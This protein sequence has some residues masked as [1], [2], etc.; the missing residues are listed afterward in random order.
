MSEKTFTPGQSGQGR[1]T[2]PDSISQALSEL[3]SVRNYL[4]RTALV[5]LPGVTLAIAIASFVVYDPM[6][7]SA[8]ICIAACLLVFYALL[9]RLPETFRTLW[10]RNILNAKS[11]TAG[12]YK[13]ST[14]SMLSTEDAPLAPSPAEEQFATFLR[15]FGHLLNHHTQWL[16]GAGLSLMVV[17]SYRLVYYYH[18]GAFLRIQPYSD[19][20]ENLKPVPAHIILYTAFAAELLLG[21]ILGVLVWQMVVIAVHVRRLGRDL[22]LQPQLSHPDRAGG[23]KPL[24]NL[25]LFNATVLIIPGFYLGG[26]II[27]APTLFPI[28]YGDQYT[29]LYF[30]LL[31]VPI[32]LAIIT[33]FIPLWGVHR[34]MVARRAE[35]KPR[36]EQLGQD[37]DRL[38]EEILE[39]AATVNPEDGE[40]M[41]KRLAFMRQVYQNYQQLPVWPFDLRIF[42]LQ[43]ALPV[44]GWLA[45]LTETLPKLLNNLSSLINELSL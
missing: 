31:L 5:V 33:L 24:G 10:S 6:N 34:A 12:F 40:K 35:I 1:I 43:Q 29:S 14:G 32:I 44:I 28:R 23:L 27:L 38:A 8:M 16:F 7:G 18:R 30:V 25:C 2:L 26:W 37:I 17:I 42:F 13:N 20:I 22:H 4:M 11:P 19:F 21:V 9:R 3:D 41:T 39:Q 45:G 15:S 36:I